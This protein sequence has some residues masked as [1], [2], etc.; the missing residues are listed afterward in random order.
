MLAFQ[1]ASVDDIHQRYLEHHVKLV[2]EKSD[3]DQ[4][5]VLEVFAYYQ[6]DTSDSDAD[7]GTV[8]RFVETTNEV[9]S[10]V[11]PGISPVDATFDPSSQAAYCDHWV[12]NGKCRMKP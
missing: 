9:G 12:S 2:L 7:V 6:G 11:L 3:Y 4:A 5:K 10:C 1:V 8:L